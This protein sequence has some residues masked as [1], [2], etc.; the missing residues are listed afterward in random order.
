MPY[1][2]LK[3]AFDTQGAPTLAQ[4]R[5]L[6]DTLEAAVRARADA[7]VAALKADFDKPETDTWISE[8]LPVL[9]EIAHIRSNLNRWMRP[10]RVRPTRMMLGTRARVVCEPLGTVL[11]IAPWN[12]PFNLSLIPLAMALAA[13]NRVCLKPS[14]L[15]P[16]TSALLRDLLADCFP[17]DLV[18]VVE[19]GP[20]TAGELLAH[21]WDHIFFT[22]S[23]RV[24]KIVMEAAAK[25]LSGVTL[26][27]GGKSPF[28]VHASADL[29]LAARK[30]VWGKCLNAGQ[31]CIAPDYALVDRRVQEAFQQAVVA[32]LQHRYPAG[33]A[34]LASIITESHAERLRG[35]VVEAQAAGARI[36][37]GSLGTGRR[38]E[39]LLLTDLRADLRILDEEIFG[40]L[41]P[42]VGYDTLEEA[43]AFVRNRPD[44]L[45][46]SLF[47]RD[48]D[49]ER[50]VLER[51][52]AG[53]MCVNEVLVHFSHGNLPFGGVNHSG[54]GK[55][56]GEW[57]FRGL[58]NEKP[59]LRPLWGIDAWKLLL[60][61]Y[62]EGKLSLLKRL[63]KYL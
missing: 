10:R 12:Y 21:P 6:L 52:T 32:E 49:V 5:A 16:H 36:V 33:T 14:E 59:V 28:I 24:G 56:H 38:Q 48:R 57:G 25:H 13:G 31:T 63:S 2:R 45:A 27:L 60:A 55:A 3:S 26:E 47:A 41:M 46:L 17:P 61:P 29:E 42:V 23:P 15:T 54:L 62:S 34:D 9:A 7:V 18:T 8:L 1:A 40:P 51:T 37:Y 44:P 35:L 53:G 4:R 30:F 50:Q 22:G 39:P 19:G 20:D 11:V 58:S 43:L